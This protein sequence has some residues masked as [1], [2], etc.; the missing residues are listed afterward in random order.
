MGKN[1]L[2]M[3]IP[4][5]INTGSEPICWKY[6]KVIQGTPFIWIKGGEFPPLYCLASAPLFP[7]WHSFPCLRARRPA[8]LV[9]CADT[10][11]Q[12]SPGNISWDRPVQVAGA[13]ILVCWL[14]RVPLSARD[15]TWPKKI[16]EKNRR[17]GSKMAGRSAQ[18]ELSSSFQ[19][20]N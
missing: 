20:T 2:L 17:R 11:T 1:H 6:S 10:W 4:L 7:S 18:R 16:H 5:F 8:R 3:F 13:A 14:P 9:K 15:V 12:Q 19:Y